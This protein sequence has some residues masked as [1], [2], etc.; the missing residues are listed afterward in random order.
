MNK[1]LKMKLV[2][3]AQDFPAI[4][5]ETEDD[6]PERARQ[7]EMLVVSLFDLFDDVIISHEHELKAQRESDRMW[8]EQAKRGGMM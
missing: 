8:D 5:D 7:L 1:E 6:M 3:L 4:I 2:A